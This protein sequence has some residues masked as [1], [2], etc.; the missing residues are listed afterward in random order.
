MFP[1]A[2]FTS[3]YQSRCFNG[4]LSPDHR[5]RSVRASARCEQHTWQE[6]DSCGQLRAVEAELGVSEVSSKQDVE[7]RHT[8]SGCSVCIPP[9]VLTTMPSSNSD[10]RNQKAEQSPTVQTSKTDKRKHRKGWNKRPS[11]G[12]ESVWFLLPARESCQISQTLTANEVVRAV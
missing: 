4:W 5:N 7:K 9:P 1:S 12:L 10:H 2:C 3:S 6:A 11:L 8:P